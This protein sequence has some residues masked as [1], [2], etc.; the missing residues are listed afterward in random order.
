M[1]AF[2][3]IASCILQAA[4]QCLEEIE[5]TPPSFGEAFFIQWQVT[6]STVAKIL[7]FSMVGIAAAI[8]E[9][10]LNSKDHQLYRKFGFL[11]RIGL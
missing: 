6:L 8:A 3:L 5:S 2:V 7:I 9:M 10:L 4:S 1:M 11:L